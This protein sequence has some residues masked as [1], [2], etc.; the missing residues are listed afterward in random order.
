MGFG[1]EHQ[2]SGSVYD[3]RKCRISCVVFRIPPPFAAT[4]RRHPRLR[5]RAQTT[6][7]LLQVRCPWARTRSRPPRR[8]LAR[9]EGPRAALPRACGP[10]AGERGRP[11]ADNRARNLWNETA[12]RGVQELSAKRSTSSRQRPTS[13]PLST[14]PVAFVWPTLLV[15]EQAISVTTA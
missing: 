1:N 9:R 6:G 4:R 8:G 2:S 13:R 12:R 15:L 7:N 3:I 10:N 5:H 11:R 14:Q